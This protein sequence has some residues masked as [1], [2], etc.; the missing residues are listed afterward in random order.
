LP[1]VKERNDRS[2]LILRRISRNDLFGPLHVV[3][4]ERKG[5]LLREGSLVSINVVDLEHMPS[6]CCTPCRDAVYI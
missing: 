2:L 6:G 4:C 3:S 5:Y 1:E